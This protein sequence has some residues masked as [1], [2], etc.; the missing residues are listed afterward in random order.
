[1]IIYRVI[2]D[3]YT[4]AKNGQSRN[5]FQDYQNGIISFPKKEYNHGINTHKYKNDLDYIHFFHFYEEAKEYINGIPS[6]VWDDRSYIAFYDIPDDLLNMYRG[7]GL[8]PESIHPNIP[9]LEYAIPFRE[10][11]DSFILGKVI[12]YEGLRGREY[13]TEYKAYIEGEYNTYIENVDELDR[14]LIKSFI[15]RNK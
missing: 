3:I 12:L 15:N 5:E 9:F 1:M 7:F 13:S 10:L 14:Q 4:Y 6:M 2:E 11:D 8:Y